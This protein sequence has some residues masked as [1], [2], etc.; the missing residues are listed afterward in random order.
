MYVC[1]CDIKAVTERPKRCRIAAF[2]YKNK[3]RKNVSVKVTYSYWS[4][5]LFFR[6]YRNLFYLF[7]RFSHPEKSQRWISFPRLSV[8][9]IVYTTGEFFP[10]FSQ[11]GRFSRSIF[12]QHSLKLVN[13]DV[14]RLLRYRLALPRTKFKASRIWP[15]DFVR[16]YGV[17]FPVGKILAK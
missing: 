2:E 8:T 17:F 9:R 5:R 4:R 3:N 14:M 10:G 1:R 6:R 11:R 16:N 7:S 15:G 12:R 13:K